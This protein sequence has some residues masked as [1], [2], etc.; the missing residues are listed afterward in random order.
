M[1]IKD[2]YDKYIFWAPT[3]LKGLKGIPIFTN[4][5][6][7]RDYIPELPFNWTVTMVGGNGQFSQANGETLAKLINSKPN[8]ELFVEIGTASIWADSSTHIF[9]TNKNEN[10]T[11]ITIDC[12]PRTIFNLGKNN[13]HSLV[14]HSTSE[15]VKS[16]IGNRKIDI[17]FIDGD[18]SVKTVFE[19]YEFYLPFMKKDGIIVLHDT[20]MHPGPFLFM[21]AID[22]A[23]YCKEKLHTD[24]LGLGIVYLK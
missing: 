22:E 5:W 24:D 10:T 8:A 4:D 13:V 21:E 16:Y 17:L 9:I 23:V 11:F 19:E 18:H 6:A 12:E 7:R 1:S 2:E 20:T 3:T 15:N 14:E